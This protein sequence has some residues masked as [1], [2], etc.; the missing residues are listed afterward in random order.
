MLT[1][2]RILAAIGFVIGT[3][4]CGWCSLDLLEKGLET[5]GVMGHVLSW[6]AGLYTLAAM[7][8][9]KGFYDQLPGHA[10]DDR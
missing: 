7:V 6:L 10:S 9:A 4:A 5:S 8:N 1:A 2:T 3:V